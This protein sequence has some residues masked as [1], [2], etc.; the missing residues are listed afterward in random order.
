M[1]V[2]VTGGTGFI[3]QKLVRKLV[4]RGFET[5]VLARKTSDVGFVRRWGG[6]IYIGDLRDKSTLSGLPPVDIIYHLAAVVHSHDETL[7]YETNVK[8]TAN[9]V[10]QCLKYDLK[11]IVFT[12]SIAAVGL[13]STGEDLIKEDVECHPVTPYGKSKL[14]CERILFY[15]FKK[16]GLP[17]MVLR[18][19][20]VYGPGNEQFLEFIRFV[21]RKVE[22]RRPIFYPDRGQ[23]LVSL[24]YIDNLIEALMLAG[25]CK[26]SGEIFNVDD[27]RPYTVRELIK[28]VARKLGKHPVEFFVPVPLLKAMAEINRLIGKNFFGLSK[29]KVRELTTSLAFDCSKIKKKLN[30]SPKIGLGE[31]IARTIQFYSR[32]GLL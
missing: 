5:I 26:I 10:D 17:V 27:G 1:R 30:Y 12:S 29:L 6:K 4:E 28:E 20:T 3:G 21:K 13:P 8:G 2:L 19:P 18:P 14:A 32:K 23:I 31:G 22:G 24:C 7:I 25:T 15:H 9:L 11:K 16:H